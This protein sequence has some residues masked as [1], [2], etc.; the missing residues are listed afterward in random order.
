MDV[1]IENDFDTY[2]LALYDSKGGQ[3]AVINMESRAAFLAAKQVP[4]M[5]I[6]YASKFFNRNA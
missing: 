4:D 6:W 3:L 1:L 2:T 5:R